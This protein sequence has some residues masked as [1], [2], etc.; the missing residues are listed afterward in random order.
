MEDMNYLKTILSVIKKHD[1]D[2]EETISLMEKKVNDYMK[3]TPP[4]PFSSITPYY[5]RATNVIKEYYCKEIR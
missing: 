2:P 3:R 5:V 4:I 1:L